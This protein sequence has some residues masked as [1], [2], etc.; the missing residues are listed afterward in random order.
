MVT[1]I[2]KH[3]LVLKEASRSPCGRLIWHNNQRQCVQ[4][5]G[6][7]PSTSLAWNHPASEFGVL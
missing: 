7:V 6:T 3:K 5:A 1:K 2:N 4:G